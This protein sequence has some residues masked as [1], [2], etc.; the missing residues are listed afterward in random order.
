[1][2]CSF[3]GTDNREEN[4]FCGICGVRLDRRSAERRV[5]TGA[6]Q[7]KCPA[8]SFV[9]E[10]GHK[11]CGSCGTRVDRRI[12]ERRG[13]GTDGRAN[14]TANAQLP[15][16][17]ESNWRQ[18]GPTVAQISG[19]EDDV[20]AAPASLS[21]NIF[22]NDPRKGDVRNSAARSDS[23]RREEL[24]REDAL[25]DERRRESGLT[26]ELRLQEQ[27]RE[28]LRRLDLR[29]QSALREEGPRN[30]A[31][32]AESFSRDGSLREGERRESERREAEPLRPVVRADQPTR[33][34][35]PSFLGIGNEPEGDYLLEDESGSG[36]GIRK[37]ILFVVLAAI[38]GLIFMQWRS[39]LQ[40]NPKTNA[41]ASNNAPSPQSK[42]NQPATSGSNSGL[43]ADQKTGSDSS[44][45]SLD[46]PTIVAA[47]GTTS[48]TSSDGAT[49]DLAS[50]Q[51]PGKLDPVAAK[52]AAAIPD[53]IMAANHTQSDT[54]TADADGDGKPDA[55]KAGKA[56]PAK[57]V[58]DPSTLNPSAPVKPSTS[59]LRAQQFL[60]GRGVQQNCEQ[61]LVYLRAAAQKNEPAAA[62]QMGAL[63]AAGQCVKQD[64][65]MAYRWFNSAHELQPA[66]QWI[67]KSM[68]QL[69][70]Q[71]NEQERRLSGY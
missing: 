34:M 36:S 41:P 56:D 32:R 9:N 62:V 40:A 48:G 21:P 28:E 66:N 45:A 61:G 64:R 18:T 52:G 47:A 42:A 68:D 38:I 13:T 51:K 31:A 50:D 71:M 49:Q 19:R 14:A 67:Q 46:D 39:S 37:L 3:C 70:A 22:I 24:I 29:R 1:M 11:Y 7:L 53:K 4:R 5:N 44:R 15:S 20:L 65:V 16:P 57:A 54:S 10:A 2:V 33:I 55:P 8:C 27:R 35:G 23:Q 63:Y 58:V 6:V 60:Q 69:W 43:A 17:D 30:G 25:I 26:E 59:L 12:S